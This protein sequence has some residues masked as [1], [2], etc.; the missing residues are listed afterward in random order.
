MIARI[1]LDADAL[2]DHKEPSRRSSNT[3]RSLL[4]VLE[5]YGY[6]QFLGKTD[7]DAL[8][9]VVE[10]LSDEMKELWTKV[11]LS[12]HDL[13][14]LHVGT[15][16][17]ATGEICDTVPLSE[18]LRS[19]VDLIVVREEVSEG[20]NL[21]EE[22]GFA[23]RDDEPELSLADSVAQCQTID[24]MR[25]LRRIG[26]YGEG[27]SRNKIWDEVFAAP[28]EV[29][30]EAT[31]LDRF[32]LTNLLSG[33]GGGRRS[34]ADWLLRKLDATMPEGANVRLLGE[35]PVVRGSKSLVEKVS[36]Q[37]R[38]KSHI[39]PIIGT[40]R[41]GSINVLLA[42][43]PRRHEGGPH[44]RHIRFAAGIAI[45]TDEGFDR[46]DSTKVQGIDGFSWRSITDARSLGD[47]GKR[48]NMISGHPCC[49]EIK[50]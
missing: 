13:N 12:L 27:T 48:E 23:K 22:Q 2:L 37:K 7:A 15:S 10:G 28:A 24:K 19:L 14:R 5:S 29:S 17:D 25:K 11:V 42:P 21:L 4:E 18:P 46:L 47:L 45:G 26:N 3:H 30:S 49:L 34:H 31:L 44:N 1:A 50:V 36:L 6:L 43:W 35:W 40:G 39:A 38:V 20:N 16:D 41:L 32:F 9:N 8:F 33:A